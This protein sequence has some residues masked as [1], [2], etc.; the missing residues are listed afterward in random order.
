MDTKIVDVDLGER[1]YQIYVGQ[2]LLSKIDDYLPMDVAGKK[3]FIVADKNVEQHARELRRQISALGSVFCELLLLPPGEKTKSYKYLQNI[4][5]WMLERGIHRTSLIVALGGGVIGDLAGFAASTVLRGVPFVQ[6]PT[7]LLAQVDSSVG[8]KTGINTKQ[9]KNL[10]GTFNQPE[11]VVADIETLKT[12]PKRQILAGYAE[13]VKYGLLGDYEF[14]EWLE[15]YGDDV[16][17]LKPYE[18]G[19]AIEKSCLAK[20][21]IVQADEKESGI[22]ALL[23]LGHTFGHAL[24]A[25]AGFSGKLLHGEAVSIGMVMAFDLSVRMDLC[26][27]D[28]LERVKKHLKKIG[29]PVH[30]RKIKTTPEELLASMRNDKKA[31]DNKMTFILVESIGEAIISNKVTEGDVLPVLKDYLA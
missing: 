2:N 28:D 20:A 11:V 5:D 8:G 4:H 24:E 30:A 17:D 25:A 23:N 14:F 22:R 18:L 31:T 9:G 13:I 12:L 15:E 16:V 21:R 7:T 29:L 10:I 1:T 27:A 19:Y 3:V 6:V 26:E